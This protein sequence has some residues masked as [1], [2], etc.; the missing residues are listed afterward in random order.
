MSDLQAQVWPQLR[1][2]AQVIVASEPALASFVHSVILS[3][4]GLAQALSFH[5]ASLL[6]SVAAPA[7]LL[8]EVCLEAFAADAQIL[9]YVCRDILACYERDAACDQYVMP[10]LYFK[11][12]HALQSYRIAH[13]LWRQNR[14]ILARHFQSRMSE[15][16]AVDIHP[17]AV[18]GGGILMDHAT[19]IVIGETAMIEDD[20]S[21]LHEVTLGGSGTAR[22]CRRH[23]HI[24]RGVLLA[25]GAKVLGP[26]EV[27]EGAKIAGGSVVLNDVPAFCTVAGVPARIVAHHS[28][29]PAL[30]MDQQLEG[31]DVQPGAASPVSL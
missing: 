16:F 21:M 13:W 24:G 1:A 25:T 28:E 10:V 31:D 6:D 15:V 7:L 5:L 2:E 27:G 17:A 19:G 12:F 20:V 30:V 26:I 9:E 23:P 29:A 14:R 11:G 18:I 3:H 4:A 22:D 8:Q